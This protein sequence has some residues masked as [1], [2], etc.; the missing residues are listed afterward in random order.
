[1]NTNKKIAIV[2][3]ILF[4]IATVASVASLS[5]LKSIKNLNYL[6]DVAAD[7]SSV[8][9]GIFLIF[10]ASFA[11]VGIA[12]SLYPILRKYNEGLALGSV[13]FRLIEGIFGLISVMCLQILLALSQE[14]V[15][16][17]SP[18][19]SQ[20]QV[21][22][23]LL[24]VGYRWVG[25]VGLLMAFSLGALLYYIIF[26]QTKLIPRWLSI[27][28]IVGTVLGIVAGILVMFYFIEPFSTPQIILA[29]PIALQEMV[30]A[31]WL[32]VKGLNPSIATSESIEH[33]NINK[34]K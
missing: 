24:L 5:F 13:V 22:G 34:L 30:F 21:L 17:G 1:M 10:T 18:N 31:I 33:N 12:I 26:Y 16:L 8:T 15:K 9:L 2:A 25:N 28:G 11:S 32:I 4:I 27:W 23:A 7:G 6:T 14:F 3:G 29:L 19:D 20:F